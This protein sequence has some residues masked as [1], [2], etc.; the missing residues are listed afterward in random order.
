MPQLRSN[1]IDV[2]EKR[3]VL[4]DSLQIKS[5]QFVYQ[6]TRA[7][8]G[9]RRYLVDTC[10][11][12]MHVFTP[13]IVNDFFPKEFLDQ[14]KDTQVVSLEEAGRES[15]GKVGQGEESDMSRYHDSRAE[16]TTHIVTRQCAR[17]MSKHH[18]GE[19]QTQ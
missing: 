12:T 2:R 5:L 19:K 17:D 1:G 16:E 14:I 6:N 10:L 4:E 3:R 13:K 7:G 11:P 15:G 9:L 18:E 8:D